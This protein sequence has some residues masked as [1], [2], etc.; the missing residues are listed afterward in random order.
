[1]IYDYTD[2]YRRCTKRCKT[3]NAVLEV[4]LLVHLSSCFDLETVNIKSTFAEMTDMHLV[5]GEARCNLRLA[6]RLYRERF[7]NRRHPC[8]K[9]FAS[10]DCRLR[11]RRTMTA[12]KLD[13]GRRRLVRIVDFEEDVLE[14]CNNDPSTN[15]RAVGHSMQI[16]H[17]IVWKVVREQLYP[18]HPQ[19]VQPMGS[20]D[21][22][23]RVN[24]CQWY[25]NCLAD[26]PH[27]GSIVLFSDEAQFTRNGLFNSHNNH[28]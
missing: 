28:L 27:F 14:M 25:F 15:I 5:F 24:F 3:L 6:E 11:E 12:N 18:Y 20:P 7:P 9:T 21:F 10:V 19:K 8:Q 13:T 2:V 17:N 4:Y 1:V 22:P 26:N 23:F 16:A